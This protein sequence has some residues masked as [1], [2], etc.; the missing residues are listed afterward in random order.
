MCVLR[1]GGDPC[2]REGVAVGQ[3]TVLTS[4]QLLNLRAAVL[5]GPPGIIALPL[6]LMCMSWS[7]PTLAIASPSPPSP[8]TQAADEVITDQQ[9][10]SLGGYLSEVL[11]GHRGPL[12][13]VRVWLG[14]GVEARQAEA[15]VAA[16]VEAH[17]PDCRCRVLK[18]PEKPIL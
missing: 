17:L 14:S 1:G 13:E 11:E 9:P 12:R 4:L 2:V 16:V 7:H 3:L 15:G 5:S 10:L 6:S 8:V 18:E